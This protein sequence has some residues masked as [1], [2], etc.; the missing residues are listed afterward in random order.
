MDEACFTVEITENNAHQ[1]A[2]LSGDWNPLHTNNNYAATTTFG[3]T[4]LHGAFSAG[5]ISRLAGME[6]PGEKCLLHEMKLRFIAPIFLPARV[7]VRG[8]TV[9]INE[10]VSTI[11]ATITDADSAMLYT[12][13]SYGFSLHDQSSTER[14]TPRP[15]TS[16]IDEPTVLI[17]GASGGI[18]SALA[19]ELGDKSLGLSRQNHRN[20]LQVEDISLLNEDIIKQPISAIVHCAWPAPDNQSFTDLKEPSNAIDHHVSHPLRDIQ[21]LSRLLVTKGIDRSPLILIGSTAAYPGRHNY[22][23]PL[24][25]IAKSIIPT[26]VRILATEL[27]IYNRRCIGVTFDVVDG[28]MNASMSRIAELAHADRMPF[29][30]I[31]NPEEAAKQILWVLEN[32]GLLASGALIDLSG[33]AI[34]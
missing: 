14:T 7:T 22:R 29:G 19:A 21:A 16:T 13:A 27:A 5:L 4:I 23:S 26:L 12:E 31:P 18:G 28:G 33:G 10:D 32:P 1:F 11:E 15:N 8:K 6:L 20:L 30:H 34:P 17:T 9:Q 25:S 24:Y 3:R 2:E